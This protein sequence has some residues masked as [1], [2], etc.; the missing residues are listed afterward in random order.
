MAKP[1]NTIHLMVNITLA[2]RLLQETEK[3]QPNRLRELLESDMLQEANESRSKWGIPMPPLEHPFWDG[4]RFSD[5]KPPQDDAQIQFIQSQFSYANSQQTLF[6][7]NQNTTPDNDYVMVEQN[8]I[9][10]D[11]ELVEANKLTM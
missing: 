2:D 11:Y 1:K 8:D 7:P 4:T 3:P 6:N 9:P 10:D 5:R